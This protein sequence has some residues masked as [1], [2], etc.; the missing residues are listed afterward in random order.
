[1]CHT[2]RFKYIGKLSPSAIA[3]IS[4]AIATSVL[5]HLLNLEYLRKIPSATASMMKSIDVVA[6]APLA[7]TFVTSP[8]LSAA[9]PLKVPAT[10]SAKAATTS[11]QNSQQNNRNNFFPN[12]PMYSSMM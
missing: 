11:I 2:P 7:T 3:T 6:T 4:N 8:A 9:K 10:T 5:I 12:L 1:M